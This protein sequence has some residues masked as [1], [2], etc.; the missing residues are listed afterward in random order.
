MRLV[1]HDRMGVPTGLPVRTLAFGQVG[2]IGVQVRVRVREIGRVVA[3]PD[4]ER[5]NHTHRA[6]AR[7]HKEGRA[8]IRLGGD[9]PR[10]RIGDQPAGVGQGELGSEQGGTIFGRRGAG[11]MVRE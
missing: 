6:E 1:D 4:H 9:E 10:D 2:V 11:V 8:G 5:E 7:E 3:G